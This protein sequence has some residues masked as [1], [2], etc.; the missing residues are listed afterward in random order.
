[1][2]LLRKRHIGQVQVSVWPD[3]VI[4]E[5]EEQGITLL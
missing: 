3:A 5:C 4:K 1:M 2:L